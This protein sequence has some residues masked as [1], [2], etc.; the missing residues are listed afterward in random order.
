MTQKAL[1]VSIY[2]YIVYIIYILYILHIYI[3]IILWTLYIYIYIYIYIYSEY[4]DQHSKSFYQGV[5]TTNLINNRK[6]NQT[7]D[8][9]ILLF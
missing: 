9:F 5:S 2:I 6:L 3:Y 4:K 7:L 1:R 8:I